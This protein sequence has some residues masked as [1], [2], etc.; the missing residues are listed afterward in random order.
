MLNKTKIKKFNNKRVIIAEYQAPPQ[1]RIYKFRLIAYSDDVAN[2]HN[3]ISVGGEVCLEGTFKSQELL[4]NIVAKGTK[5]G[6]FRRFKWYIQ[7]IRFDLEKEKLFFNNG[8]E[9]VVSN[10]REVIAWIKGLT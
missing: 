8:E 6:K 1:V 2:P 5:P 7:G 10:V 4:N 3:K 9:L